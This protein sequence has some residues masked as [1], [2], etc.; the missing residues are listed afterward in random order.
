MRC[1]LSVTPS[2]VEEFFSSGTF[3]ADL[4]MTVTQ[5]F[6]DENPEA[7]EEE[8]E[9]DVSYFAAKM[10]KVRED[11]KSANG[12]ALAIEVPSNETGDMTSQGVVL[13]KPLLWSYV[14]AILVSD[15]EESELS[16]YAP[17]EVQNHL[18]DWLS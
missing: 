7:D 6:A 15:S 16:W 13:L 12:F 8:L 5:T 9:F 4:G 2:E 11:N 3:T 1:Y 18:A 14:E 10:S 17:Q